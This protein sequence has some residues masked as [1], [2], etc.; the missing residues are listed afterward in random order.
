LPFEDPIYV[1]RPLLPALDTYVATLEG[2][3]E[4]RWLTNGGSVHDALE[5]ALC[6]HL[7]VTHLSLVNNG[8][9][10][11]MLAARALD[12]AGE[13]ITTPLT[14]PATASALT[15][16]GLTPVFA[17]VDPVTLTLD[18]AAVERAITGRTAAIV[19]VHIYGM[20]CDVHA[21]ARIAGRHGLRLIYDGA[22]AFGTQID[23][24]PVLRFGDA[25]ALSFHATKLFNT[26]E[27][28]AVVVQDP[29]LERRIECLRNL[30]SAD[31][32]TVTWPG[33]NGMMNELAAALGLANLELVEA[34]DRRRAEVAE[35]YLARL[36][37]IA[38]L[39][40]LEFPPH[41]RNSRHYFVVRIDHERS[42]ISRDDLCERLTAFNVFARRYFHPL[43]SEIPFY[44]QLRSSAP[45]NL[46]VAHRASREVLCL[47]F[48]G[49]LGPAAAERIC[50]IIT[51]L[52]TWSPRASGVVGFGLTER[53]A[54]GEQE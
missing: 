50:D 52:A 46:P 19:G 38:G 27:G 17:D 22:H 51:Y 15:W 25:T 18:P 36:R 54:Q 9:V 53:R 44:R 23:G 32:V 14:S 30:G 43:C 16:C 7:R 29:R 11:L 13:V 10:A 5:R 12:L 21:L 47:P 24:E 41:V 6:A 2:I 42:R 34:E 4:R 39:S 35:V 40:C 48:Y 28:G 33:I 26:A 31:E 49:D 3:W 45:G 1:T 20:P 8:T 37:D